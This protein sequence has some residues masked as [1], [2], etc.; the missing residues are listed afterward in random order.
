M[1][2]TRHVLRTSP[3]VLIPLI[4]LSGAVVM[5]FFCLLAGLTNHNP[6]N[7][8]FFLSADTSNIPG[9]PPISQ[10]TMNNVCGERN[11]VNIDCRGR[12]GGKPMLPQTYYG[13]ATGVPQPFLQHQNK[14]YYLSRFT[15]AFYIISIFWILL[16]LLA[17]L[18]ATLSTASTGIAA[19]LTA[20]AL[21][22]T[23]FLASIM[24]A[25][26]TQA[27]NAFRGAGRHAR[28]G[29]KAFAF[30]WT[31]FALVFLSLIS[32][33]R[34]F[35]YRR[36]YSR[37]TQKADSP[38]RRDSMMGGLLGKQGRKAGSEYDAHGKRASYGSSYNNDDIARE[39]ELDATRAGE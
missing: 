6:L 14:F 32:L 31:S 35:S 3:F 29:V 27:Q 15:Y 20:I 19:L 39:K 21:L 28:V 10:F 23:A 37:Q 16:A 33:L 12:S 26:Y 2:M 13:T 18:G 7:R 11:G 30:T 34:I 38:S 24:T 22:S 25:V 8:V 5:L 9:A 36:R 1:R 4:L 17:S